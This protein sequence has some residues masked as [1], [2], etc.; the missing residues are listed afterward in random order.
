MIVYRQNSNTPSNTVRIIL[1]HEFV[2]LS[3]GFLYYW[4][5]LLSQAVARVADAGS[6][7]PRFAVIVGGAPAGAVLASVRRQSCY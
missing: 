6:D 1:A 4:S 7:G 3:Y 5:R 2:P